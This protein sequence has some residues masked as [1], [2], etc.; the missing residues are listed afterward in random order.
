MAS[1]RR[2]NLEWDYEVL[3]QGT[4]RMK[5]LWTSVCLTGLPSSA[6]GFEVLRSRQGA[7]GQDELLL[8]KGLSVPFL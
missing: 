5:T 1:A 6:T 3:Y 4:S 2:S 7:Q 8:K